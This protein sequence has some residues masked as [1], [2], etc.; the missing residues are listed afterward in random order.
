M[1]SLSSLNKNIKNNQKVKEIQNNFKSNYK[2]E[3]HFNHHI[4]D[5]IQNKKIIK[6]SHYWIILF[7]EKKIQTYK[8]LSLS[9]WKKNRISLECLGS[10]AIILIVSTIMRILSEMEW[11]VE[12]KGN[13]PKRNK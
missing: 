2:K 12:D 9:L 10:M 11:R 6:I 5:K 8:T 13:N 3:C 4:K 7:L 1:H